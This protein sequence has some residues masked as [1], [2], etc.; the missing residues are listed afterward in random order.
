MSFKDDWTAA[1]RVYLLRFLVRAGGEAN[2][3]VI[4]TMLEH[5]GFGRDTRE[6][7]RADIEH[8]KRGGCL[9]DAWLDEVRVVSITERGDMAAQGRVEVLGVECSRWRAP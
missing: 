5:G 8:L 1:R 3:S 9:T 6:D 2:E 7:F 4:C